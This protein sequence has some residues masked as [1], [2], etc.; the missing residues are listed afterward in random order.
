[1]V[2]SVEDAN[3]LGIR[4]LTVSLKQRSKALSV[5]IYNRQDSVP[6]GI[7]QARVDGFKVYLSDFA[8]TPGSSSATT[9]VNVGQG[10][11]GSDPAPYLIRVTLPPAAVGSFLSIRVTGYLHLA[12]IA[13]YGDADVMCA[14]LQLSVPNNGAVGTCTP[15]GSVPSTQ[16]CT[17]TCN[18]G[19]YVVG[20]SRV[21]Q[22]DTTWS[23]SSQSCAP[24]PDPLY[25]SAQGNSASACTIPVCQ[26]TRG[27]VTIHHPFHGG[28]RTTNSADPNSNPGTCGSTLLSGQSCRFSC[29]AGYYHIG[30]TYVCAGPNVFFANTDDQLESCYPCQN[31]WSSSGGTMATCNLCRKEDISQSTG[32]VPPQP[33]FVSCAAADLSPGQVCT[34]ACEAGYY[35]FGSRARVCVGG[36]ID[37]YQE[38]RICPPGT[39]SSSRSTVFGIQA[40]N[41]CSDSD[42]NA[43]P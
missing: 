20:A 1:M 42:V 4:Q 5:H 8:P 32:K 29:V 28:I 31:T 9:P 21:C 2:H 39:T 40:C 24:C 41:L 15:T 14:P 37:G 33:P 22:A 16:S 30:T 12:E 23:G 36:K 3:A 11:H 19:Y 18:A 27:P 13:V 38:C 34:D 26:W 7:I 43:G 10:A 35:M 6:G 25:S 17:I